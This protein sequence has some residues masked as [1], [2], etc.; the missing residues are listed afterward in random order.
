MARVRVGDTVL[1]QYV[2]VKFYFEKCLNKYMHVF[3]VHYNVAVSMFP[4]IRLNASSSLMYTSA[5]FLF[6][7]AYSI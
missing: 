1:T 3:I 2:V 6:S 4:D 7:E 5:G